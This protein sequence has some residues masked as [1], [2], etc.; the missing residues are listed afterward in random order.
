[1]ERCAQL[2]YLYPM[3]RLV[4]FIAGLLSVLTCITVLAQ[5]KGQ[6]D[7][8]LLWQISGKGLS[9]PS[10]LFG[11]IHII[12]AGDYLWTD[13]MKESLNESDK[14]CFEMNLSD[15]SLMMQVAAG[16]IDKSGKKLNDYFTPEQY[17][18]LQQYIKDSIGM[19]ITMFEQ[20]KPIFLETLMSTKTSVTCVDPVSYEE[21][22]AKA[23]TADK[24]E[25]M[26]LE[27]AADQLQALETIPIDSVIKDITDVLQGKDQDDKQEY[28]QLITA[29]KQQDLPAL[30]G[31]ITKSKDAGEDMGPLLDD[32]NKKWITIMNDKMK[33]SSVFF[34]VGA[35]HLYGDNGVISLLEKHGYKVLPVK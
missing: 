28:K 23:A 8:S 31:L 20:M 15:P 17:K 3:K 14:V 2:I 19:D 6:N 16:L 7:H 30:Y 32:R 12:C 11:T 29:Y 10:Y 24:K 33:Q 9:R 21:T 35:G 25:I 1:M 34:A 18:L 27:T 22:I 13:K 26:G 4:T 5:Q